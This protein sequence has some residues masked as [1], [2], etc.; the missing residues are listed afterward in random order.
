[1]AATINAARY[2]CCQLNADRL[3]NPVKR[4]QF[5]RSSIEHAMNNGLVVLQQF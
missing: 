2:Q 1:M 3:Q 5:V 4:D